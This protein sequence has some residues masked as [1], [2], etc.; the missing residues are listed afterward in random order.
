MAQFI[1]ISSLS[2]VFA[3]GRRRGDGITTREVGV[4][5]CVLNSSRTS[6]IT[7]ALP[8]AALLKGEARHA[9]LFGEDEMMDGWARIS[10]IEGFRTVSRTE[11]ERNTM[12]AVIEVIMY[13][14][15]CNR[16]I[17]SI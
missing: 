5:Q 4:G 1:S 11:C 8:Q 10:M 9:S 17:R 14:I 16:L 6:D 7:V 2:S 13:L 15:Y 12:K 3:I